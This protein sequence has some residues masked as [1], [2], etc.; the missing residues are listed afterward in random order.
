VLAKMR[1]AA[2]VLCQG[3]SCLG[4]SATKARKFVELDLLSESVFGSSLS[5]AGFFQH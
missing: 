2:R 1:A 4:E 3:G 5:G